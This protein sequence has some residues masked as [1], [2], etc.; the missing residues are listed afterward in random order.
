MAFEQDRLIRAVG[1][2]LKLREAFLSDA[3]E[4]VFDV[5]QLQNCRNIE[6]QFHI[7]A[8]LLQQGRDFFFF[9]L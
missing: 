8:Y 4:P 5:L 9:C 1:E 6:V 2:C 3:S 7:Q